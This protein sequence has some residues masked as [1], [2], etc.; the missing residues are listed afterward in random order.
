MSAIV[1]L[2]S[3]VL[4]IV[5]L[6][7]LPEYNCE[8][9]ASLGFGFGSITAL[10]LLFVPKILTVYAPS[11]SNKSSKIVAVAADMLN[12][13]KKKDGGH[14][15]AQGP[16]HEDGTVSI[17]DSERMMKGKSREQRLI[18]CQEQMSGWQALL[19]RQQAAAMNTTSSN[20]ASGGSHG[21]NGSSYDLPPRDKI[22]SSQL[23]PD[24]DLYPE[25][26]DSRQFFSSCSQAH[27]TRSTAPQDLEMQD[28]LSLH[29]LMTVSATS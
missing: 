15:A 27:G 20:S 23:Q 28:A 19:I 3:L 14:D 6:L 1:L 26:M 21:V 17:V 13:S 2:S 22:A 11:M 24:A 5:Y 9:I 4:P 10:S 12:S 7:G 18:I 29:Y 8:L 16:G 25:L